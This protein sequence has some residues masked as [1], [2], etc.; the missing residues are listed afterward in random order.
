MAD[1]SL[2]VRMSQALTRTSNAFGR[3]VDAITG[4]RLDDAFFEEM[5]E[6]LIMADTG[7]APAEAIVAQLRR[8]TIAERTY[9]ADEVRVMLAKIIADV[10]SVKPVPQFEGLHI[11]MLIGVNGVGKTTT[12]GKLSYRLSHEGKKVVVAA[13]DTFR[14]AAEEQL[15]VW[16]DR[17]GAQ[18]IQHQHGADPAAVLFDAIKA[19][20]AREA[21]VVVCDTAGRLHNKHHLM[22]ELAKV[23]RIA[24]RE[25]VPCKT[26]LVL[27]AV[28]GQNAVAQAQAF[29][30]ACPVDG[31][32]VTKLDGTAK[33]GVVVA[34]AQQ[35]E[36]PVCY[37]GVGEGI[38]DIQPFDALA[39]ARGMVGLAAE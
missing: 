26:F 24:A 22:E 14:A 33:G 20:Q 12:V 6:L 39:F 38:E 25:Q 8:A 17:A 10:L 4:K 35:L 36:L 5:E 7:V 11:L 28:T 30:K 3:A 18:M 32:I 13:A 31:V 1:R 29:M 27:D 2:F 34:I 19:A 37:V 21:D 15:G 9:Q 16:V 23:G